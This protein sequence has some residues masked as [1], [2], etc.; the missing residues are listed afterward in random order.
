MTLAEYEQAYV[1]YLQ[2]TEGGDQEPTLFLKMREYGPWRIDNA[3]DMGHFARVMVNF[4]LS[5]SDQIVKER[6]RAHGP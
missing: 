1:E 3:G 6:R 2:A 5:Y 4:C